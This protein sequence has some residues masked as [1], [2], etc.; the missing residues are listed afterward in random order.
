MM[1]CS[2]VE[3]RWHL[4][5]VYCLHHQGRSCLVSCLFLLVAYLACSFTQKTEAVRSERRWY[6]ASH[7]RRLYSSHSLLWEPHPTDFVVL[8]LLFYL[9]R[10]SVHA[11]ETWRTLQITHHNIPQDSSFSFATLFFDMWTFLHNSSKDTA[12]AGTLPSICAQAGILWAGVGGYRTVV[13]DQ[14]TPT[15]METDTECNVSWCAPQKNC[16]NYRHFGALYICH[17]PVTVICSAVFFLV[18]DYC[19]GS[20]WLV[21]LISSS[22]TFGVALFPGGQ[23][24][25]NGKTW[26]DGCRLCYCHGGAEMCN[27]S[28]AQHQPA[29]ILA[30]MS[31]MTVHTAQVRLSH[32]RDKKM[33]KLSM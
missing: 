19:V 31:H 32:S 13:L 6:A 33:V 12:S 2:P 24:Q 21:V 11:S 20:V 23:H 10:E 30:S 15:W 9:K 18:W 14:C 22:V 4:G 7:C 28:L 29:S 16:L 27:P 5:G 25:D 17:I 3:V 8:S 1:P 26:F